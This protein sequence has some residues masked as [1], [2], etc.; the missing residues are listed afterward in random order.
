MESKIQNAKLLD[1]LLLFNLLL[2]FFDERDKNALHKFLQ[3][4]EFMSDEYLEAEF[5]GRRKVIEEK[6]KGFKEM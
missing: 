3:S 1:L 2:E 6:L 5:A 4:L